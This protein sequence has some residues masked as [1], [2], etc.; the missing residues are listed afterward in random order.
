[1]PST[2]KRTDIPPGLRRSEDNI[3]NDSREREGEKMSEDCDHVFVDVTEERHALIEARELPKWIKI[4]MEGE[5]GDR[6][7]PRERMERWRDM[8]YLKCNACRLLR[9]VTKP[10]DDTS[11]ARL[12]ENSE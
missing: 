1:M 12:Q 11:H 10:K 7:W 4:L 2:V 9:V 6:R 3:K 8:K 5:K